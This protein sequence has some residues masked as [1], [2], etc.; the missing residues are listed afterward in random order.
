[1]STGLFARVCTASTNGLASPFWWYVRDD[2]VPRYFP[3]IK[4]MNVVVALCRMLLGF[5]HDYPDSERDLPRG[6]YD[7]E[8]LGSEEESGED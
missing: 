6:W 5:A 8:E 4:N 1:M 3:T 2:L 7:D